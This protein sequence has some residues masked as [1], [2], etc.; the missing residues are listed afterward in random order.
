MKN[1]RSRL[2]L[3]LAWA[4]APLPL[5]M[6]QG[7]A[8]VVRLF[9]ATTDTTIQY[10]F[11]WGDTNQ[12]YTIKPL[13][14][15]DHSY[16]QT[17]PNPTS[18]P[19]PRIELVTVP[20]RVR[21]TYTLRAD[22]GSQSDQGGPDY[23]FVKRTAS[24]AA[25][26]LE[27]VALGVFRDDHQ[28]L[29]ASLIA[30]KEYGRAVKEC[31][32][33]L[34]VDPADAPTFNT[35]GRANYLLKNYGAA[36]DDFTK[37][38]SL[39]A[40]PAIYHSNRGHAHIGLGQHVSA[41]ADFEVAIQFDPEL[42]NPRRGR[43]LARFELERA[44]TANPSAGGPPASAPASLKETRLE[45]PAGPQAL[46]PVPQEFEPFIT[47][48]AFHALETFRLGSKVDADENCRLQVAYDRAYEEGRYI[49]AQEANYI[50]AIEREPVA[51]LWKMLSGPA[52]NNYYLPGFTPVEERLDGLRRPLVGKGSDNL[53]YVK[54]DDDLAGLR[55]AVRRPPSEPADGGLETAAII[56]LRWV[57]GTGVVP[58]DPPD[59][60]RVLIQLKKEGEHAMLGMSFS[61]TKGPDGTCD[62]RPEIYTSPKFGDDRFRAASS[63]AVSPRGCMDCHALGFNIKANKFVG[64]GRGGEAEFAAAIKRMPGFEGFLDDARKKGASPRE[65]VDAEL[66]IARPDV[67]LLPWR[68]LRIAVVKLWN[69]IYY[70]NQPYLDDADGRLTEYHDRYGS[71]W[72]E[73][74]DLDKALD[75]FN[76]AI[77]RGPEV[78]ALHLKRGWI[79]LRKQQLDD[80]L[81]D[82]DH[83]VR[84][85]PK[86]AFAYA[87]RSEVHAKAGRYDLAK[88]DA[89]LAVHFG[90]TMAT[91][92]YARA[93]TELMAG[94]YALALADAD[95]AIR[96]Q[97]R[98]V[99]AYHLRARLL[100]TAPVANLRNGAQA[101]SAATRACELSDWKSP[102]FLD[103]LAAAY[104]ESGD[105]PQAI[106]WQETALAA[107]NLAKTVNADGMTAARNRLE[108]YRQKRP[109]RETR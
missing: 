39:D 101:V 76:K 96:L 56:P 94:D 105:F 30:Q 83:S 38:I 5:T 64:P 77:L 55:I 11:Q 23:L 33:F 2:P 72:L 100:A 71:A 73:A 27:L 31:D 103:T 109:V 44:R 35:R 29:V 47:R 26:E 28:K 16:R 107:L 93:E 52:G 46:P 22:A 65:I 48:E 92:L 54:S 61:L 18:I 82:L 88:H 81:R 9:N 84:L 68:G 37:A 98:F 17:S 66:I 78:S 36:V 57:K 6:A 20:D 108:L 104:A 85:D 21:K 67:H 51:A 24:R 60:L 63:T 80:A 87:T 25:D 4:L 10:Q 69:A 15:A 91:A 59:N 75:H 97:P 58:L 32:R 70:A 14:H 34:A 1:R 74:G 89:D 19:I 106:K 50:R 40:K 41:L 102:E 3:W 90:P 86:S 62:L 43:E 8:T 79:Y 13:S 99:P 49:D 42:A 7:P 95:E 53:V 12:Q 45:A